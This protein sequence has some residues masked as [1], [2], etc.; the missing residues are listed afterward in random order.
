VSGIRVHPEITLDEDELEYSF[1][2]SSGPG[3]QKVNK[4]ATCVQLRFDAMGSE[5]LPPRVKRRLPELA[6]SQLTSSGEILIESSATRSQ[7]QNR[8]D[9][10]DRLSEL[11]KRAAIVPKRRKRTRPTLASKKR[12]LDKKRHRGRIKKLRK[13]P[14]R[15]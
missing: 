1:V 8:A 5:N 13:P 9:A 3:G 14:R 2:R 15:E 7:K 6:G 4:T 11:L 12:R 10:L